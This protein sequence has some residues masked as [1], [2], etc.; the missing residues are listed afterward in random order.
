[1]IYELHFIVFFRQILLRFFNKKKCLF[2]EDHR[3][4]FGI[5]VQHTL[6]PRLVLV[7]Y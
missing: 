2:D 1:M 4:Y 5:H 3:R 6:R 7:V